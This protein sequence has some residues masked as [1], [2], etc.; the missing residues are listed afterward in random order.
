MCT[1]GN[2]SIGNLYV[3]METTLSE[4]YVYRWKPLYWKSMRTDGNHSIGNLCVQLET[5]L[6]EIYVY[7]WKPLYWKSMCTDGNHSIGN[8]CVQMET[9]L[10][11]VFLITEKLLSLWLWNFQTFSLFL[12][13]VLWKIEGNCISGSFFIADLWEVGRK[14]HFFNFM[15]FSPF[16]AKMKTKMFLYERH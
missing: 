6:L 3:Q 13:T 4:I 9:T 5:T 15:A 16:Q 10:V 7:R 2:H 11:T 8:L 14:K 12:L 1:N